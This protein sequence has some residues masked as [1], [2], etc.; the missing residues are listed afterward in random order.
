MRPTGEIEKSFESFIDERG[1]QIAPITIDIMDWMFRV[2]YANARNQNDEALM[3]RVSEEYLKFAEKKFELCE[4]FTNEVF[5][6]QVRQIL[7]LHANELNADNFDA[8]IKVI[9]ARGY[10]F[11]SLDQAL[12]HPVYQFP[13]TYLPPSHCRWLCSC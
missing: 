3:K 2:V 1:Y 13:H 5:G 8:L 6:H 4:R 7:L 10:N 12:K 11:I 9:E